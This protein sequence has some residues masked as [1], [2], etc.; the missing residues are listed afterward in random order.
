MPYDNEYNRRIKNDYNNINRRYIDHQIQFD[1]LFHHTPMVSG[2]ASKKYE[3][4]AIPKDLNSDVEFGVNQGSRIRYGDASQYGSNSGEKDVTTDRL[5][6]INNLDKETPMA[7][8]SGFAR[9]TFRDTGFERTL[10]AGKPTG[11]VKT[12]KKAPLKLTKI[13]GGVKRRGRPSKSKMTGG[14]EL[15]LPL[16]LVEKVPKLPRVPRVPKVQKVPRVPKVKATEKPKESEKSDEKMEGA[17][18]L[19]SLWKGIKTVAKP[20]ASVAKVGLSLAPL[21]QAQLAAAALDAAGAGK[22]RG[23]PSKMKMKGGALVPVAN[24]KSSSMAGQG[25][26]KNKRAEIV[27]KI[28]KEKGLSMI[29]AS[30]YVKEHNLY[31]K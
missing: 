12:Y 27:K 28:M 5:N 10:G 6:Y 20:L 23:R 1:E 7:G 21:P 13:I 2:L 22:K 25:K 18:F 9:G 8:G 14:T 16:S 15:G 30:K 31:S 29:N 19:S 17:G 26:P 24:M 11:G 3:G 4:G